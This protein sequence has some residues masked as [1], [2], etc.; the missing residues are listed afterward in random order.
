MRVVPTNTP[1]RSL[2]HHHY[3]SKYSEIVAYNKGD[4][5]KRETPPEVAK[6]ETKAPLAKNFL[7]LVHC[8]ASASLSSLSTRRPWQAV[9]MIKQE[10]DVEACLL[11]LFSFPF[12][13]RA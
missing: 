10:A 13:L 2:H 4:D 7:A 12:C 9:S 8:I 6:K 5:R 1:R 3:L 11:A